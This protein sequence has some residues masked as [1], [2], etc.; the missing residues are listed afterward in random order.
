MTTSWCNGQSN[1]APKQIRTPRTHIAQTLAAKQTD[2]LANNQQ[3][4]RPVPTPSSPGRPSVSR[5][6]PPVLVNLFQV[7]Y[8]L[9]CLLAA[10][11]RC[12]SGRAAATPLHRDPMLCAVSFLFFEL[13]FYFPRSRQ[14]IKCSSLFIFI[15][16]GSTM[17]LFGCGERGGGTSE[18]PRVSSRTA[19][20]EVV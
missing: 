15:R 12:N 11:D 14:L 5:P 19:A 17:A 18:I 6:S 1:S 2:P 4:Q 3:Q 10:H 7:S 16:V 8:L 9:V 20:G 13:S